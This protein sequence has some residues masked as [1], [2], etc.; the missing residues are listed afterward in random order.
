LKYYVG[1]PQKKIIALQWKFSVFSTSLTPILI[2][3]LFVNLVTHVPKLICQYKTF[4]HTHASPISLH[5][6][7]KNII[8]PI[9][10]R[11]SWSPF[12]NKTIIKSFQWNFQPSNNIKFNNSV[13]DRFFAFFLFFLATRL[14]PYFS[15]FFNLK[16]CS[17]VTLHHLK[18][19][20]NFPL[21]I[22]P[23]KNK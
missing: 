20:Q 17:I 1:H 22:S 16:L 12:E 15:N 4:S 14:V 7:I 3:V 6:L 13:F 9:F 10:G 18:K 11:S 5:H 2:F 8:C 19:K 21:N 23:P